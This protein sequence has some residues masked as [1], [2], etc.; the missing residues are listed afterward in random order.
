MTRLPVIK[1]TRHWTQRRSDRNAAAIV[2]AAIFGFIAGWWVH[3]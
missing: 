3:L 2:F 1:D